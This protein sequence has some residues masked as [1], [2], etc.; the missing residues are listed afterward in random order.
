MLDPDKA[1]LKRRRKYA[2]RKVNGYW[3][4]RI[5]T[6]R[7]RLRVYRQGAR[8]RGLSFSLTEQ[9]FFELWNRTCFYCGDHVEGI[10]LDRVDNSKGYT[11]ENVVVC[12]TP[13]NMLKK[14]SPLDSFLHRCRKIANRFPD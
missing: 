8:K 10:G 14:A 13:C 4:R 5:R 3:D 12:C 9:D 2:R 7:W 6:P 11:R 1:R